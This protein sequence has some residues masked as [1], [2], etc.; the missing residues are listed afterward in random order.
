MLYLLM[1]WMALTAMGWIGAHWPTQAIFLLVLGGLVYTIGA[2]IYALDRPHL[3]PGKFSAHD[4]WHVFV[5]GGGA[6]HFALMATFVV[7]M[8]APPAT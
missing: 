7:R 4:L 2:T 1:G 5:L 3:V 8:A 6:L